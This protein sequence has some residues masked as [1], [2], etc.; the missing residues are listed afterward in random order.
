[1][2][3]YIKQRTGKKYITLVTNIKQPQK[4]IQDMRHS[5]CCN[6]QIIDDTLSLSGDQ[7]ESIKQYLILKNIV[8]KNNIM[9][10]GF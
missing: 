3:I 1:V 5:L 8:V 9:I 7:R 4:I 2:H 6:V 10:H